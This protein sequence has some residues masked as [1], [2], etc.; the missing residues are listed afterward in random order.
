MKM[1][2][3]QEAEEKVLAAAIDLGTEEVLFMNTSGRVLAETIYADRP[4]PACD[5]STMD[6]IAV[7]YADFEAGVRTFDIVGVQPAGHEPI[8]GNKCECVEVMTGAGVHASFDT[9]VRYEDISIANGKATI[10]INELKQG[11]AIHK[12]GADRNAGACLVESGTVVDAAVIAACATVGKTQLKVFRQPRITIISTGN[13]LVEPDM[14]ATDWQVRRSNP[15]MLGAV[16]EQRG[17]KPGY[18]HISDDEESLKTEMGRLLNSNDA[19]LLTG[20]VSMG[21]FDHLPKVLEQLGVKCVFHK[22]RQRPG[23]PF[24]FGVQENGCTIFAFPGNPVS[25]FMCLHRYFLPWLKKSMQQE[26]V[27][28]PYAVLTCDI[29]FKPALIYFVQV[30]L[31][32][33]ATGVLMATPLEGH[34][35]GDLANL[36][37]T[38]AFMQLPED[39]TQFLAGESFPVWAFKAF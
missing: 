12:R 18:L 9:V 17:I 32:Y 15:F 13:E 36:L 21:K 6:G 38:H 30:Q 7:K 34:G 10:N 8:A 24:Y 39:R 22:I 23:K 25:S 20:G 37:N 26:I 5:R 11:L 35:S 14:P 31:S 27:Q 4:F 16:V 2:S 33:T 3:V 28:V 19:L 1:I 29:Q